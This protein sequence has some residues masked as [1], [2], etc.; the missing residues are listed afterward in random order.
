[1]ELARLVEK[2]VSE[3]ITHFGKP[4]NCY[5]LTSFLTLP[6]RSFIICSIV[7]S[8]QGQTL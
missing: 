4:Y 2:I 3:K 5:T 6:G 7:D 1:M 8:S